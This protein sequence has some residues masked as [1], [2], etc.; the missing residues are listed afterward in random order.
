MS[1][2]VH[3]LKGQQLDT[4]MLSKGRHH[5]VPKCKTTSTWNVFSISAVSIANSFFSSLQLFT[6]A[7]IVFTAKST[8]VLSLTLMPLSPSA[9]LHEAPLVTSAI[10]T[11]YNSHIPHSLPARSTNYLSPTIS[12]WHTHPLTTHALL[13]AL[14]GLCAPPPCPCYKRQ[15][16]VSLSSPDRIRLSPINYNTCRSFAGGFLSVSWFCS[17]GA[18]A[19]FTWRRSAPTKSFAMALLQFSKFLEVV[20]RLMLAA[21]ADLWVCHFHHSIQCLSRVRLQTASGG[22]MGEEWPTN[23]FAW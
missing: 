16:G 15:I 7:Q 20:L 23:L 14:L 11:D 21:S 10:S 17:G 3:H 4:S 2:A 19:V 6:H 18:P 1:V 12:R 5:I 22:G 9:H 8:I 13:R